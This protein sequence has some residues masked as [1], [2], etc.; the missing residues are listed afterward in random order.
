[1]HVTLSEC[2]AVE[3]G[4]LLLRVVDLGAAAVVVAET[5]E[6]GSART[7]LERWCTEAHWAVVLRG[8]VELERASERWT[9]APGSA[10][11]VPPGEPG[12]RLSGEGRL[13]LAG[14][15]PLDERAT[16]REPLAPEAFGVVSPAP[17]VPTE[18]AGGVVIVRPDGSAVSLEEGRVRA[19]MADMGA[20]IFTRVT[21]GR[22][23]GYATSW[24]DA[25]HYGLVLSGSIA[26]E[27]EDDVEVA[28]AGDIYY[29][30][31]GPPGHRLEV[32]DSAVAIDFTP[33]A[34]FRQGRRV[35]GWRP[36]V[37]AAQIGL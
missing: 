12:H 32:A 20:W 16:D 13:M 25:T 26:I 18:G 35:A 15:V 30:R 31:A 36:S 9:L 8:D 37:L 10:F 21:F 2:P 33:R 1:L 3:R 17:D 29:C 19:E 22:T 24:C 4:R 11:H 14:M 6:T 7:S 5:P 27:W 23:S 28:S 34:A